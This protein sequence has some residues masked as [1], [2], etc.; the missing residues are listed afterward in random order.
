MLPGMCSMVD[1]TRAMEQQQQQRQYNSCDM[2]WH[3]IGGFIGRLCCVWR[4]TCA[5]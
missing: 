5:M 3:L 1:N 2:I 4:V